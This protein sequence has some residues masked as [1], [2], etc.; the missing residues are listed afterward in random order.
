M[1]EERGTSLA[2]AYRHFPDKAYGTFPEAIRFSGMS[3]TG[4]YEALK[5]Q[6]ITAKKAGR[7]TLISFEDL[8]AYIANLPTYQAGA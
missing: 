7:R 5:R 6:H 2:D 8:R 4:L 3:R 1:N